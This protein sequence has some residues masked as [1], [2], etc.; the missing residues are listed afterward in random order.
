MIGRIVI[1][2]CYLYVFVPVVEGITFK[3]GS[4]VGLKSRG[5][6]SVIFGRSR[7]PDLRERGG[8]KEVLRQ[9]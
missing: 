6:E 2:D 1:H 4:G 5:S 3:V 9:D 8:D 7:N